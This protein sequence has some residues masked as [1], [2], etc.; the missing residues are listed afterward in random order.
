[1]SIS[2]RFISF[3]IIAF[4]VIVTLQ[5]QVPAFP[6]AG[7]GGMYATGGRGG[8]VI[9]VTSVADDKTPG[10]FR[11]AVSQKGPRTIIFKVSGIIDL[12]SELKI[13]KGDLT[14]AGQTAPGDGIC[15]KGYPVI[16]EAENVIVRFLRFRMGDQ[17]AVQDDAFKGNRCMNL[18][19][20]HCS[21]SWSTDE[22]ASFY[23][24][25]NFTMQYCIV[26]E[27]LRN[28]V[29]K[30]GTHGYGGIWGGKNVSFHHNL[31]AHHDSRNPRFNGLRRSGLSYNSSVDE[32]R[33]D[34]R[35]NIIYNWGTHSSYG[36]ESGKYNIV[37]N[38]F[39]AGPAT[40]TS[41]RNRITNVD[42]DSKPDSCPPGYGKYFIEKNYVFGFK[43]VTDDNWKGVEIDKTVNQD[44]CK[45]NIPFPSFPIYEQPATKAY[46]TILVTAG[47]SLM[48]DVV[49]KRV[50]NEVKTGTAT[51]KGSV[52]HI[53]GL[54]DSQNDVGGWPEY[55]S[56]KAITDSN[57]DGIP[58]GWIEKKHPGKLA[59]DVDKSGY[60]Y[61]EIY[62]NSLVKPIIE[63]QK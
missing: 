9:Y 63:K 7:G 40:K 16:I 54:I 56:G 52:D 58:D 60:T 36:G 33:V 24:N 23:S 42:I 51:F 3:F 35:N 27:S 25:E 46:N 45:V 14:I 48:R 8:K 4:S 37:A 5:A 44:S 19:I 41:V 10:T 59:N 28:S 22:C 50:V 2:N 17:N 12:K 49:D 32:D 11:W 31:I 26:S 29:H 62:L 30:K 20:D 61:L 1:M 6:G 18:I 15:I 57:N 38:Y 55:K 13:N 53:P 34:F 21:M 39:K 47:A 43:D